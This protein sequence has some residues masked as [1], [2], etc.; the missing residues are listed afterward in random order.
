MKTKEIMAKNVKPGATVI[1]KGGLGILEVA[2]SA[3][4][5]GYHRLSEAPVLRKGNRRK[6]CLV[7]RCVIVEQRT[8]MEVVK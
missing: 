4:H 2:E 5:L 1:L 7:R 3:P 8:K 6:R